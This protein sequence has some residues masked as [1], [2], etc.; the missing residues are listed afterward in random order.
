MAYISGETKNLLNNL[1][2]LLLNQRTSISTLNTHSPISPNSWLA[3]GNNIGHIG[4]THYTL[5]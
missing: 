4:A 1:A 2:A 3:Y 5:L